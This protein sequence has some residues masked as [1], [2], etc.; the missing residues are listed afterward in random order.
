M[1]TALD[2]PDAIAQLCS[3]IGEPTWEVATLF[4]NQ[5]DWTEADYFALNTNRLVELSDGCLEIL[6]MAD[7]YH[8]RIVRFMFQILNAFIIG[9][10]LGEVL[11]APLPVR[12]WPGKLREPDIL[13][14]Q[15]ARTT[16]SPHEP[17]NAIDLAVEVVSPGE[18]N[19]KRDL[20]TKPAEYAQAGI[21]EYWIV[22]PQ[23]QRITVLTLAANVYR[24]HGV[25]RPGDE[26]TSLVL[27]GFGVKV[28][29][30][31]AAGERIR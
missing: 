17:I 6:P 21:R 31:F 1:P 26:A 10:S 24:E 22:D 30:V 3:R 4:P 12:L 16:D 7:R 27:P 18:E 20:I 9:H 2:K 8:Q 29:E 23:E 19:R 5:G 25:F 15:N 28:G 11:F 14:L 13:Y